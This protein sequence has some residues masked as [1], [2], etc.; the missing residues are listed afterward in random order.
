MMDFALHK[1]DLQ[2]NNGDLVL[3]QDDSH[4]M[5]Q[6]IAIHLNTFAGEWFLD[7]DVG[8]PYLTQI[9]GKKRNQRF[10]RQLIKSQIESLGGVRELSEFNFS[11]NDD[12]RRISI[13]FTAH[14]TDRSTIT[15]NETIGV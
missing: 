2:I 8:V 3:C 9:L 10:L 7:T 15:I 13:K 5:A 1:S 12:E 4:A 11:H 14:L 6:A